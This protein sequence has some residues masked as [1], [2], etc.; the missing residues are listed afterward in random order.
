ML[1]GSMSHAKTV[2]IANLLGFKIGSLSFIYL[3][4]LSSKVSPKLL[5]F[6][7]WW[8]KL[9]LSYLLGKRRYYPLQTDYNL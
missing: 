8:T 1:A 3:G 2:Q 7:R 6:N 5:I 9:E 4:A